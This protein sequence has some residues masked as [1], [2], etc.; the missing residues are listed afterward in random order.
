MLDTSNVEFPQQQGCK[1]EP[2]EFPVASSPG[3]VPDTSGCGP[4]EQ[5]RLT[6][7]KSADCK[8]CG[9]SDLELLVNRGDLPVQC[10]VSFGS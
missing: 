5:E 6:N 7:M 10:G 8:Y 2:M 4:G 9:V 1:A 3:C